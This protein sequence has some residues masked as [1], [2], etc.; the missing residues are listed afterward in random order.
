MAGCGGV[1]FTFGRWPYFDKGFMAD[2]DS[3]EARRWFAKQYR[4]GSASKSMAAAKA[5]L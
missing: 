4:P 1:G 2:P 5:M 3:I